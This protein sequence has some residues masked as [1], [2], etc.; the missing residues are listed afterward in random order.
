VGDVENVAAAAVVERKE[1]GSTKDLKKDLEK[2]V[3]DS[4]TPIVEHLVTDQDT[5]Q[6]ICVH[7]GVTVRALRQYNNFSG[8]QFRAVKVVTLVRSTLQD[9]D[10]DCLC[11]VCSPRYS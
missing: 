1:T 7:Y 6:G 10:I 8:D 9:H 5:I 2:A 3:F 11:T 4:E